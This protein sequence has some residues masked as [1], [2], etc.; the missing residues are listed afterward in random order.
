MQLPQPRLDLFLLEQDHLCFGLQLD[1]FP[2]DVELVEVLQLLE[3]PH[4]GL[5]LLLLFLHLLLLELLGLLGHDGLL[6]DGLRGGLGLF[7]DL[8]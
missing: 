6:H 8:F 7:E 5:V 2:P 1:L 4:L 3:P